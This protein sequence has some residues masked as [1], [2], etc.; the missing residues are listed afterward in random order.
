MVGQS[1]TFYQEL[2]KI[3][4]NATDRSYKNFESLFSGLV[5]LPLV[6]LIYLRKDKPY[7]LMNP[8]KT[9]S[10]IPSSF[11]TGI[12]GWLGFIFIGPLIF[13][14]KVPSEVLFSLALASALIQVVFLRF[15]FFLLQM[16]RHILV[17]AFWGLVSAIAIYFITANYFYEPL[18]EQQISWLLIYAYIGAP[19][20]AFLSYFYMDDKKLNSNPGATPPHLER[21]AHWLE[22]FG[23]GAIAYLVSFLPF[24]HLDLTI[25]TFI[26]GAMSGVF[27]AGASHFSSDAWKKSFVTLALVV[28]G[29]GTIQGFLSGLLFRAYSDQLYS[30]YIVHGVIGGVL[31]YL[32]TFIRGRQLAGKE[33][34]ATA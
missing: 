15:S 12:I 10:S 6:K 25:N 13:G 11:L 27:A 32:V 2:E 22:P 4:L 33:E 7:T 14:F 19:V 23:Y 28:L 26:V 1:S 31:T 5:F 17:G 3:I 18:K 24:Q 8:F 20:G 16:F 30:N 21:D 29:V 34:S 9:R